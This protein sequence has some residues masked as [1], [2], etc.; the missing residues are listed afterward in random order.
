M[1]RSA[2]TLIE[3]LVVI[4]IIALLIGILLPS[5]AGARNAGRA[6]VCQAH[7]RG[8]VTAMAA[9]EGSNKGY[10]VGPNTSGSDLN[11][12]R[13]YVRGKESPCQDW[14]YISPLLGESLNLPDDQLEKFQ[15]VCMNKARCPSN[16]LR[17]S[18]RFGGNPLPMEVQGQ[19]PITLSYMTPAYF[20]LYPTGITSQNGRL[21]ESLP[22]GEPISLGRGFFPRID[23]IG[24][25]PSKKAMVFEGARYWNSSANGFDY[26]T[27]TNTS[28]LV[29][30]PQGNFNSRGSAFI[31]SGENYLRDSTRGYKPTDILKQMSLRHAEKMN[32]GMFDGH[33]EAF[34]NAQ[35]SNPALYCPTGS[36][37]KIPTATWY[38][39]LGPQNSPLRQ[40]NSLIP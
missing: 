30:T 5:L 35:S 27:V 31:A 3:L 29:G 33:V 22:A 1:R 38:Y 34:D 39:F 32:G 15:E 16:T 4:A 20:Q 24:T 21:I 6:V 23:L 18:L 7:Q 13:P 8:I 11:N 25:L 26:A 19:M 17:Y 14:D 9:Y 37:M 36:I 10:L 28:G 12:N 40:P 2:F